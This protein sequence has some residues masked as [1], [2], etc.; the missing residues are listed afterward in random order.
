MVFIGLCGAPNKGKS[1][2][3]SAITM[4]NAEIA[5]YPFTTIDPNKGIAY[6]RVECPCKEL[7]IKCS[8]HNSKCIKNNR[9]VPINLI[10]IAGLVPEAHTGKGLGNK[11]LTE[12]A[13]AD[14]LI[15]VIDL[16]GNTN[17]EGKPIKSD[18]TEEIEFL[19]NEISYWIKGIIEKNWNKIKGKKINIVA[20]ILQ[21]LK[22]SELDVEHISRDLNLEMER[23][24]WNEEQI[25]EFSKKI[26]EKSKPI[27]IAGNKFDLPNAKENLD[28]I[29]NKFPD[30]IIIPT[31][32]VGELALR[33]AADLKII[34]YIPGDKNFEILNTNI[35]ERQKLGLEQIKKMGGTG[36]QELI[37]KAVLEF[38]DMIVVYPVEDENK[39][40]NNKG[41]V[42]PDAILLKN[43]STAIDLAGA[44]HSDFAD[45]FI[46]AINLRN[47]KIIGKDY[48]LKH[49]DIIKIIAKN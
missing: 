15:Q 4:A 42:L 18:P 16:S 37:N 28:K 46:R 39:L 48:I 10:D 20:E 8:P 5:D 12:L 2:L 35:D 23:I 33:K 34:D 30:K 32:G 14:C 26:R 1:T 31:C 24:N 36:I 17:L 25:F 45:N 19:E 3:F 43:G 6:V 47:K 27:L 13:Q 22:I 38:L 21:G 11:F 9:F 44:I 7:K 40:T 41:E 49:N 29:K